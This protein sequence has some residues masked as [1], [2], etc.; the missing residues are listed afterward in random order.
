MVR[1]WVRGS[2][3]DGQIWVPEKKKNWE[4]AANQ[5]KDCRVINDKEQIGTHGVVWGKT[6]DCGN[7]DNR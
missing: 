5:G 1:R 7:A 6:D 4:K 2:M 3:R